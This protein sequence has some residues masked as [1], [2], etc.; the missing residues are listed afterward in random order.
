MGNTCANAYNFNGGKEVLPAGG[1]VWQFDRRWTKSQPSMWLELPRTPPAHVG[2]AIFNLTAC[3]PLRSHLTTTIDTDV[4]LWRGKCGEQQEVS[5]FQLSGCQPL[6]L[7]A[8]ELANAPLYAELRRPASWREEGMLLARG[9]WLGPAALPPSGLVWRC[10][11]GETWLTLPLIGTMHLPSTSLTHKPSIALPVHAAVFAC[12]WLAFSL[13][14]CAVDAGLGRRCRT[15][16]RA[17]RRRRHAL[18]LLAPVLAYLL[19]AVCVAL[20]PSRLLLAHIAPHK[21]MAIRGVLRP[22]QLPDKRQ[23]LERWARRPSEAP[24][25]TVALAKPAGSTTPPDHSSSSTRSAHPHPFVA[26]MFS[27]EYARDV[28]ER[29][30]AFRHTHWTHCAGLARGT[31]LFA[32]GYKYNGVTRGNRWLSSS[33]HIRL[34]HSLWQPFADVYEAL[35]VGLEPVLGAP[36]KLSRR[37]HPPVF[38]MHIPTLLQSHYEAWDVH[39]DA[40]MP[41]TMRELVLADVADGRGPEWQRATCEWQKQLTVLVALQL[42]RNLD[43]GLEYYD[44]APDGR[45]WRKTTL[46]HAVGRVLILECDRPHSLKPFPWRGA[47]S[48]ELRMTVHAFAVPC[49]PEGDESGERVEWWLIGARGG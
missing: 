30:A 19:L 42:P 48:P 23:T 47:G 8:E 49:K 17:A 44:I 22:E 13:V 38:L 18:L 41:D 28:A 14:A 2:S 20:E 24:L 10:C 6:T 39:N 26:P 40:L 25:A 12:M 43:A 37:N 35:R 27:E 9:S 32:L 1:N 3:D 31:G 29:V 7:S 15:T 45:H 16:Y 5:Q 21:H 4:Y 46:S 36:C 33:E 34:G 11:G